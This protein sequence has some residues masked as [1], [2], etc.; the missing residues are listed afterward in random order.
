MK[1]LLAIAMAISAAAAFAAKDDLA[2][3]QNA[4]AVPD[5]NN[6]SYGYGAGYE[7][8]GQNTNTILIGTN[9]GANSTNL[10]GCT[11]IGA[12]AG[13]GVTGAYAATAIGAGAMPHGNNTV[14][15]GD[16]AS[17]T[18]IYFGGSTV[19]QLIADDFRVLLE[20]SAGS[21]YVTVGGTR[22]GRL[23]IITE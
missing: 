22:I 12:N 17:L 3:S 8:G 5:A 13:R 2:L 4:T 9:A 10:V 16:A 7:T 20:E 15:L 23:N 19:R 1:R 11:F 21:I 6:I 18:N 14:T